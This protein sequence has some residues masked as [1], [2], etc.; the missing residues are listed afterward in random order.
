MSD[1]ETLEIHNDCIPS[2]ETM[3][4]EHEHVPIEIPPGKPP[5][6]FRPE[7]GSWSIRGWVPHCVIEDPDL[8]SHIRIDDRLFSMEE[9]GRLI[10]V[11]TG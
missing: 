4:A 8:K 5:I 11:Y 9:F 10:S 3:R 2:R 1:G 6:V 7:L